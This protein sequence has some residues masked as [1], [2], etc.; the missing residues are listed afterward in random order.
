MKENKTALIIG[1]RNERSI[2][3]AIAK[4]LYF[5]GYNLAISYTEDT[6]E[7]VLYQLCTNN[8]Y[9]LITGQVDVRDEDQIKAFCAETK[10]KL[11]SINYVLHSV[12]YGSHKVLCNKAPFSQDEPTDYTDIPLADLEEAIDIG[13]YSLL[14]LVRSVQ[15]FLSVNA[16]ILTTTYN[17]SQR[18][19]PKYAG[20][21]M[22]KAC[23]ENCMKYLAYHLGSKGHRINALSP[24]LL[25]TTSAASIQGVRSMRKQSAEASPLGN[26]SLEDVAEAAAYY[27]SD[28]SKKVTGNIH[29]IDGGLNIMGGT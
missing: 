22:V 23:L 10:A 21:A 17:A 3:F 4:K 15:P 14:R 28:A 26:I 11:G 1:I 13:A 29:Y 12:A 18:V 19:V 5:L 20:M 8:M 9:N 16:S 24:G 6:K 27:F 25:M 7:E 2:A